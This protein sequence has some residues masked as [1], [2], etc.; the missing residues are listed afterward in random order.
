MIASI[1]KLVNTMS[2]WLSVSLTLN[3]W[4]LATTTANTNTVDDVS[5]L[6]FV[7]EPAGLVRARRTGGAV[8]GGELTK[9][10][11]S[12]TEDEAEDVRLLLLVKFLNELV[13]LKVGGD[14]FQ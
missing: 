5:L 3:N 6:G 12:N 7:S 1:F 9:F 2:G 13:G 10:P 4:P 14:S 8:D 11:A